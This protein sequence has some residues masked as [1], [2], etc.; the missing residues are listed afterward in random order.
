MKDFISPFAFLVSSLSSFAP[1]SNRFLIWRRYHASIWVCSGRSWY[2]RC[3]ASW[4]WLRL[5]TNSLSHWLSWVNSVNISGESW[6]GRGV[7]DRPHCCILAIQP[8]NGRSGDL[9]D[10]TDNWGRSEEMIAT[11]SFPSSM[12]SGPSPGFVWIFWKVPF[13]GGLISWSSIPNH[14]LLD[15]CVDISLH[16]SS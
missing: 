3:C 9:R 13:L 5:G 8:D 4:L 1:F 6:V 14:R 11:S 10:P 15:F 16:S 7:C 12:G 2:E